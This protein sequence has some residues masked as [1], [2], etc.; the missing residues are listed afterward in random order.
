M[1]ETREFLEAAKQIGAEIE[2]NFDSGN[3]L[4]ESAEETHTNLARLMGMRQMYEILTNPIGVLDHCEML[5]VN[6]A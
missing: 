1:H 3:L 6:D 5:E 4:K 2:S